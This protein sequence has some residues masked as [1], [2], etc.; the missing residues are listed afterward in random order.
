MHWVF[1]R[2]I[3]PPDTPAE[4]KPAGEWNHV[5]LEMRGRRIL[6]SIN[7]RTVQNQTLDAGARFADGTIPALNR[8]RGRIGLQK[9]SGTVRFR[10][11]EV[12]EAHRIDIGREL[13]VPIAVQRQAPVRLARVEDHGSAHVRGIE[14]R[15]ESQG[16]RRWRVRPQ[17]TLAG[18]ERSDHQRRPGGVL[19]LGQGL[20]RYRALGRFQNRPQGGQWRLP[21]RHAANPD[22]GFHRAQLRQDGR[23]QGVR[24]AL[25]QQ[26]RQPRQ[27][28]VGAG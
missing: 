19:H 27:G 18:R 6:A 17:E 3:V 13:R 23:R 26:P 10:N 4:M 24:R 28:P 9:L 7:G 11:I 22:L 16:S 25:E 1:D 2:M 12:K 5:V 14:R 15:R 21:A 20:R 8:P